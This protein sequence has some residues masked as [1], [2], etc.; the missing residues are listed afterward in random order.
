MRELWR[1][2]VKSLIKYDL[3]NELAVRGRHLLFE[4]KQMNI[5]L[6]A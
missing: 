5:K 1:L 2:V 3:R 6:T 4:L